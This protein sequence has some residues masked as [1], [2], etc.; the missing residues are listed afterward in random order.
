VNEM[1]QWYKFRAKNRKAQGYCPAQNEQEVARFVGYPAG[2]LI[3]E[4]VKWNGKE[5]V[6]RNGNC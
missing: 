1:K 3:I 5:F 6:K 4:K 2:E